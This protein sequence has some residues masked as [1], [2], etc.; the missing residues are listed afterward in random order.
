[1]TMSAAILCPA[2]CTSDV[3]NKAG[4]CGKC[5]KYVTSQ[6]FSAFY[7]RTNMAAPC[8]EFEEK[9]EE[10]KGRKKHLYCYLN[11]D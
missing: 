1:M 9:K 7:E 5:I 10:K 3:I 6:R 8:W 11:C 2:V 4:M